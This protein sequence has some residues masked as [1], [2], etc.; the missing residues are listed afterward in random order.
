VALET[1]SKVRKQAGNVT[2][3]YLLVMVL[4]AVLFIVILMYFLNNQTTDQINQFTQDM[5]ILNSRVKQFHQDSRQEVNTVV[6]SQAGVFRDLRAFLDDNGKVT[7]KF[8]GRS[9]GYDQ[10]FT[11][12]LDDNFGVMYYLAAIDLNYCTQLLMQLAKTASYL[13]LNNQIVKAPGGAD[14]PLEAQCSPEGGANVF[15]LRVAF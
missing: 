11:I 2:F 15:S 12:Y 5:T 13:A 3:E 9:S 6:L 10:T 1:P 8:A 14:V 7:M 4:G